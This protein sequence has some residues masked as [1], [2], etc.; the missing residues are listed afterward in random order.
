MVLKIYFV[1][2]QQCFPVK[3]CDMNIVVLVIPPFEIR[4]SH[5]LGH[6]FT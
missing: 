6:T 1:M 4:L 2:V 3:N 5:L